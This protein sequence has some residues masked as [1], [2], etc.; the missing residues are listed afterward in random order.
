MRIYLVL[1]F[2]V[3]LGCDVGPVGERVIYVEAGSLG[4]S[5]DGD[6]G[7]AD[8]VSVDGDEDAG[9][10]DSDGGGPPVVFVDGELLDAG[11]EEVDGGWGADSG[12]PDVD[13]GADGDSGVDSGIGEDAGSPLEPCPYKCWYSEEYG[14]NGGCSY[15][16]DAYDTEVVQVEGYSCDP[17]LGTDKY[18]LCC[19]T[20]IPSDCDPAVIGL[21]TRIWHEDTNL[22]WDRSFFTSTL[23][24]ALAVCAAE[25]EG[26]RV[27]TITELRQIV[28]MYG[29]CDDPMFSQGDCFVSDQCTD[30]ECLVEEDCDC[31]AY[32]PAGYCRYKSTS[33]LISGPDCY[34]YADG[35]MTS[36]T[37]LLTDYVWKLHFRFGAIEPANALVEVMR[38]HCVKSGP[39]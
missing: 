27:P 23:S 2:V 5:T 4:G 31:D 3:L 13:S 38:W 37:S 36:V 7:F 19:D 15:F 10:G 17:P 16:N 29:T 20:G 8:I 22:C 18:N 24:E 32:N 21:T 33:P 12:T 30:Y 25:G 39:G 9:L 34:W 11:Q 1:G 6:G 14:P 35:S 28:D 26:W